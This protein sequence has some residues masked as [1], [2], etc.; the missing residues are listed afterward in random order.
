MLLE[1]MTAK[2]ALDRLNLKKMCCRRM[3]LGHVELIDS[4]LNYSHPSELGT[5]S[6]CYVLKE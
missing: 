4:L 5:T 1:G 6:E 3:I 2:D